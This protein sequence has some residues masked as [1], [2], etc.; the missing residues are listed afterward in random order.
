MFDV[1][2]FV[3]TVLIYMLNLKIICKEDY[4]HFANI[5]SIWGGMAVGTLSEGGNEFVHKFRLAGSGVKNTL[6]ARHL[7]V[8]SRILGK[9]ILNLFH[10]RLFALSSAH[11]SA[12]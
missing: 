8:N 1:F 2:T 9:I 7:E 11:H 6:I 3:R 12:S 10:K 4:K 5:E